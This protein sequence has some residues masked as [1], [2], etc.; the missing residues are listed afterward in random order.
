MATLIRPDET[1]RDAFIDMAAEFAAAG[2]L[3]YAADAKNFTGYLTE[4]RKR[5]SGQEVA[6]GWVRDSHFWLVDGGRVLGCSRLRHHL[7][8][9]LEREGGHI[10]YDIRPSARRKGYGAL[11]LRLTL[12]RA[13]AMGIE[14][15]RVTCDADN[16]AS[17][18]VIEGNG[19]I[20][21]GEVISVRSGKT[22]RQYWIPRD[23]AAAH[24]PCAVRLRRP[25]SGMIAPVRAVS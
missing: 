7:T 18:R 10:G 23:A 17:V 1:L 3:R 22:I 9:E 21:D 2:E 19:G 4:T 13:W 14:R 12:Q 11:L 8:P 16:T 15:I 6:A 24:Q 25:L 5:E 20:L